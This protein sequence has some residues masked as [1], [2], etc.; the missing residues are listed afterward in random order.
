MGGE[1]RRRR[2]GPT[3]QMLIDVLADAWWTRSWL[4]LVVLILTVVAAMVAVAGQTVV[5][6]AIYPAL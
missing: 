3:W 5:P 1:F 2:G 4:V 6:W